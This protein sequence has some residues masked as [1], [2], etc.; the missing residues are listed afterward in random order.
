MKLSQLAAKPQL[1]E[2]K[3]D[4]EDVIKEFG[5]PLEFWTWDRQPIDVF[6]QLAGASSKEPK[7]MIEIMR[8]LILDE[9][10]K[11]IIQGEVMLPSNVLLKVIAKIVELLGK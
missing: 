5:E 6:M 1:V 3:L 8:K 7:L 9:K 4:D 2:V 10:G 11:E